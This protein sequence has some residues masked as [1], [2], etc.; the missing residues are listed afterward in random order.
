METVATEPGTCLRRLP[1]DLVA[2][3]I[4]TRLPARSLARFASVCAAWR[5]AI[6][7]D[8]SSFLRRRR[9]KEHSSSFLLLLYA[10]VEDAEGRLAFSNHV[11]FYR[12]RW[13][14][15]AGDGRRRVYKRPRR[16][17][18]RAVEVVTAVPADAA[19]AAERCTLTWLRRSPPPPLLQPLSSAF[20][21]EKG[22]FEVMVG[23]AAESGEAAHGCSCG[24]SCKCNPC[25]C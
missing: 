22:H 2:D 14:D 7:G 21:P 5:A 25:N 19:V 17:R 20:A 9:K 8:P 4:L 23:K 11:P 24:S 12:L 16:S 18:C 6:S 13:P 1:D 3:E 15:G 10:L